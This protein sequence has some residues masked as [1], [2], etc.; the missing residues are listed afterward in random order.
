MNITTSI[1]PWRVQRHLVW[2][3]I[4][5]RTKEWTKLALKVKGM[6]TNRRLNTKS[7]VT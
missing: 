4:D 3:K 1:T 5:E 7:C 6:I 2:E